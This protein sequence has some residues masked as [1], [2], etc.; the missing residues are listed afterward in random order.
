M[1]LSDHLAAGR[2][3]HAHVV[4]PERLQFW[5]EE[6]LPLATDDEKQA[7]QTL[8]QH[9]YGT[10]NNETAAYMGAAYD[11]FVDDMRDIFLP[12][13]AS[14]FLQDNDNENDD[15]VRVDLAVHPRKITDMLKTFME[16]P[17]DM[18]EDM[19][20]NVKLISKTFDFQPSSLSLLKSRAQLERDQAVQSATPPPPAP[21]SNNEAS[22]VASLRSADKGLDMWRVAFRRATGR[23]ATSAGLTEGDRRCT[24]ILNMVKN[25]R[26]EQL[27]A[28]ILQSGLNK[29]FL[30]L[31]QAM[32]DM[33]MWTAQDLG[34]ATAE[35]HKA[36]S[37][38]S[39]QNKACSPQNKPATP[40]RPS[41]GS[42]VRG[43]HVASTAVT[44][45]V[46]P[47]TGRG[48]GKG[49]N[50]STK[51]RGSKAPDKHQHGHEPDLAPVTAQLDKV[52]AQLATVIATTQ[53][54]A[55]ETA[56]RVVTDVRPL[57]SPAPS[58]TA[59]PQE[60]SSEQTVAKQLDSAKQA[61][62]LLFADYRERSATNNNPSLNAALGVLRNAFSADEIKGLCANVQVDD[63]FG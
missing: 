33:R 26:A 22:F 32:T 47:P 10:L 37:A 21:D 5:N 29:P 15:A 43:K 44:A 55:E 17:A 23:I 31:A 28:V 19:K 18:V 41:P 53:K 57:L 30:E 45:P 11:M 20:A 42:R 61:L 58:Q 62:K 16:R 50:A 52:Q 6:G 34:A 51:A 63:L 14:P 40:P 59:A 24:R 4:T 38:V 35:W 36:C 60:S 3:P 54:I 9:A 48:A 25:G 2:L 1:Y 7:N 39:E 27:P 56:S 13:M 46:A 12:I 49:T 8:W